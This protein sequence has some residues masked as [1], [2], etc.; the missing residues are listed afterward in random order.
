[1]PRLPRLRGRPACAQRPA[2]TDGYIPPR[3]NSFNAEIGYLITLNQNGTYSLSNVNTERDTRTIYSTALATTSIAAN[4]PIPESGVIFVED[5]VWVRSGAGGFDGRV[6]IASARLAVSGSTVVTIA[7][8][9]LYTDKYSGNDAIGLIAE[10]NIDVAP[11][12]PAPVEID[13]ALI[14]QTGRVQFR[15]RYNYNG[16]NTVGYIDPIKKLTF[17]G[18]VA[19]NLQWTWSWV[20]CGSNSTSCWSGFKY[21]E[22][23]YDENLR[24]SPPPQFP[25]TSTYDILEWREIVATP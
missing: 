10:Y 14:A 21:N 13:G 1:M 19:S 7:D 17:Y 5:N 11:Y 18:S 2:R 20:R 9:L 24:Y 15:P 16:A 6:T 3:N 8:N 4:I 23:K 12:V 22:T 25:V